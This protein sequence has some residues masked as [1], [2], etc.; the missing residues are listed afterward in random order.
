VEFVLELGL[1]TFGSGTDSFGVVAVESTR[2]LGMVA[3]TCQQLFP[4]PAASRSSWCVLNVQARPIFVI[5]RNQ[6][7][8]TER[9][10]HDALFSFCTLSESQRKIAYR[11]RAALDPQR[12][13]IVESMI[14][15][16]YARVL[17]H[18]AGIGLQSG[19]GAANVAV[20]LYDL[21]HGR[22]FE[23]GGGYSL[24]YA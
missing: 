1:G 13:R 20:N 21:F 18:A 2:W 8:H 12:L 7:C 16:L 9:S 10:A 5:P 23:E 22:G 3:S 24:L 6:Q 14:L 19:H 17:D 4:G 15:A 11:L